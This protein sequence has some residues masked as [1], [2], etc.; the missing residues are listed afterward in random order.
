MSEDAKVQAQNLSTKEEVK[1][2]TPVAPPKVAT[3]VPSPVV[4]K[5]VRANKPL[6]S[7]RGSAF[8]LKMVIQDQNGEDS[9][10]N[11]VLRDDLPRE[12]YTIEQVDAYWA[13]FLK[14]IK[15]QNSIPAFNALETTKI[16]LKEENIIEFEFI[17]ASS[18]LEFENYKNRIVT[19][20]RTELRNHYF[21]IEIKFAEGEA[22]SHI[23]NNKQKF[24]LFVAKNPSI[25]L[26][27]DEL[28]LDLFE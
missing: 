21:T 27:K 23:L 22:K 2:V 28:G 20:L 15:S 9:L 14:Q 18:E 13:K 24:E 19:G 11:E 5:N 3:S 10:D 7:N 25:A 6:G 17:S 16:S 12:A 8:S 4:E 1:P 26:L